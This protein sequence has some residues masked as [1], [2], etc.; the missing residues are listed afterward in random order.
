MVRCPTSL[1]GAGWQR[2]YDWPRLD[3]AR[4]RPWRSIGLRRWHMGTK[5]RSLSHQSVS[6]PNDR[7]RRVHLRNRRTARRE[8]LAY[9]PLGTS[10]GAVSYFAHPHGV[11]LVNGLFSVCSL[12]RRREEPMSLY[13]HQ[14]TPFSGGHCRVL[15]NKR[16]KL[17]ARVGYRMT[18][19]S[20]ARRSLSAI[21]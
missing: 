19:L 17:P 15:P 4:S 11:A 9:S 20:S 13:D 12:N 5:Q 8:L 10:C 1:L 21:R 14:T 18:T 7:D 6:S 2:C 16:L 3:G